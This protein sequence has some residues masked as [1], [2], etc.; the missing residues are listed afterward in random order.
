MNGYHAEES[1]S[2]CLQKPSE[3]A[4]ALYVSAYFLCENP[5]EKTF[6]KPAKSGKSWIRPAKMKSKYFEDFLSFEEV[7]K[8]RVD[9]Y[10][11]VGQ[12]FESSWAR[13]VNQGV[14]KKLPA[15]FAISGPDFAK[16][17]PKAP[18]P[19][20]IHPYRCFLKSLVQ[21]AAVLRPPA[22]STHLP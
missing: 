9:D 22:C 18:L 15:P 21:E 6:P 17:S 11:S 19:I 16:I 2:L 12:R 1:D 14:G 4:D 13:Q 5:C 7:R 3:K 20:A 10:E 8:L